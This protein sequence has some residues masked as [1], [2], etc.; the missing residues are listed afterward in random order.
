MSD[1]ER[2]RLTP[3][4]ERVRDAVRG[5]SRPVADPDFRARLKRGFVAGTLQAKARPVRPVRPVRRLRW[6][7]L[8][9]VAAAAAILFLVLVTNRGPAPQL[10]AVSGGGTVRVGGVSFTTDQ[11]DEI[12]R[13]LRPGSEVELD[14]EASVAI[15]Y[16]GSMVWEFTAGS[17]FTVPGTPGRWFGRTIECALD[18]GEGRIRTGPDFPGTELTIDTPEGMTVLTGTLVSVYR[19]SE[20]T[21]V[22]VEDGTAMIGAD[23]GDLELIHAGMRKVMFRDGRPA[24]V[25]E[26]AP[27][28]E[29]HLLE[30]DEKFG[31]VFQSPN[32]R[33]PSSP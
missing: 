21:C 17:R 16:P 24:E 22:C 8:L 11:T 27:S 19:D 12:N 14:D 32:E 26:I 18:F 31:S 10:I 9:P 30:F 4:E 5:L 25:A 7:R 6:A 33:A 2:D 13:R 28:H 3:E 29:R 15:Y 1:I 23:P 20:V